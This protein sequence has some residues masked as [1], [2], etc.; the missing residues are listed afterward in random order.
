VIDNRK[1]SPLTNKWAQLIDVDVHHLV[2]IPHGATCSQHQ[3][4]QVKSALG[5]GSHFQ[6]S[7]KV[8]LNS[9]NSKNALH[10]KIAKVVLKKAL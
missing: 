5:P 3:H 9:H 2:S 1:R 6:V 8:T 7:K 10:K 4:G